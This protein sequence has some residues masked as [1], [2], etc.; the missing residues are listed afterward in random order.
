MSLFAGACRCVF[1]LSDCL[2]CWVWVALFFVVLLPVPNN[3]MLYQFDISV[4]YV[5]VFIGYLGSAGIKLQRHK[6]CCCCGMSGV[7]CLWSVGVGGGAL[8]DYSL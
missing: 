8:L 7:A 1:F 6:V 2:N 4:G 5:C 3:E